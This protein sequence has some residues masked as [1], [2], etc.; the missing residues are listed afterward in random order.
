[1]GGMKLSRKCHFKCVCLILTKLQTVSDLHR[2]VTREISVFFFLYCLLY[3]AYC[4]CKYVQ[5]EK[6]SACSLCVIAH[7][8][9]AVG[10]C[11]CLS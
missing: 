4:D 11:M 8:F 7:S 10:I 2:V 9:E 3:L 5:N 1:M 6:K